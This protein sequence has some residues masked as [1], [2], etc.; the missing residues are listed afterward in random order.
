MPG[1]GPENAKVFFLGQA[2]GKME[3]E[4]GHPFV[5]R[6]GKFLTQLIE[7]IGLHRDEVFITSMVKHFPP[8]NRPPKSDE[9]MACKP[10]LLRQLAIIKPKIVVL[11]GKTAETIKNEPI[12][13]GK[14]VIVTVHPAA[15]MRFPK[16]AKKIK[17]DFQ[18]LKL[19]L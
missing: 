4:T 14:K 6:A 18:Q 12:L 9:I 2:P 15:A 16:M 10:Y 19:L 3:D 13:K 17:Q 8:G 5:G 11:L 1:E 7:E